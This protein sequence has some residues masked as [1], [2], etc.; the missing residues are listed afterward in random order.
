[1]PS[2]PLALGHLR[3]QYLRLPEEGCQA[4]VARHLGVRGVA[5]AVLRAVQGVVEDAYEV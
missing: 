5:V 2:I 1:M 4:L 3:L